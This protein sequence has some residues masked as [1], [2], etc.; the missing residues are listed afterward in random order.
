MK[1]ILVVNGPN[2]NLLGTREPSVYGSDWTLP[3]LEEALR[4]EAARHGA[5]CLCVQSNAEADLIGFIQQH[6][7]KAAGLLINPGGLTH[8]SV[9]LRDAIL[10]V[11]VR[12]VEVHISNI[13]KREP[14]RRQSYISDIAEGV[15]SGL[16]VRGYFYALAF[17]LET[18]SS[19]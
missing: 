7:P 15:I 6:G 12:T 19:G 13:H 11:Q 5:E 17:L 16:G 2:L 8:T 9:A 3:R 1:T 10:A 14:F 18:A 4:Q